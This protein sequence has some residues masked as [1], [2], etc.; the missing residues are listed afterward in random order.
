MFL[1]TSID[2]DV[3]KFRSACS[4]AGVT[5]TS[6]QTNILD[7]LVK[8]LKSTGI[9]G[10][11]K[12]IYPMIGGVAASHKFN[13]KDPQDTNGAFRLVFTGSPTHSSTGVA[14]NGTTQ[15]ADTFLSPSV[16]LG[17][18]DSH[19]SYYSRTD[20]AGSEVEMGVYDAAS[21]S[22]AYISPNYTNESYH[23]INAVEYFAYTALGVASKGLFSGSRI[24]STQELHKRYN[25]AVRTDTVTSSASA[26]LS[27]SIFL[28]SFRVGAVPSA[29]S[30]KQCAFASI[31]LG[32]TSAQLDSLYTII[33][34]YQTK[35]GRQV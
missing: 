20:S 18:N 5:L 26:F 28:G 29:F 10:K 24:S 35:L 8:R 30:A 34:N 19:L 7:E 12:A 15:Y 1:I 23:A 6:D 31:G 9:W 17:Q 33:Q 21:V 11:S 25:E 27:G 14:W 3:L 13:L 22:G 4:G 16:S 2:P 32:L